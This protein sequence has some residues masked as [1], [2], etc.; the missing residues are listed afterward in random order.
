MEEEFIQC[1]RNGDFKRIKELLD[2]KAVDIETRTKRGDSPLMIASSNGYIEIVKILLKHGSN[3]EIEGGSALLYS[4]N[5]FEIFELLLNE[6]ADTEV[7]FIGGDNWTPLISACSYNVN[8]NVKVLNLLLKKGANIN[9]R[10]NGDYHM[11]PLMLAA[12]NGLPEIID[13]LLAHGADINDKDNYNVTALMFASKHRQYKVVRKLLK[14]GADSHVVSRNN[15][16]TFLDY[17]EDGK[18]KNELKEYAQ[19]F[20]GKNVKSA[21]R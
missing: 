15:R 11:T 21:K 6:G 2:S 16:L 18:L 7:S 9:V 3:I 19:S 4:L 17:I 12:A 13:I 8:E 10:I 1:C 14:L 5:H 20:Q